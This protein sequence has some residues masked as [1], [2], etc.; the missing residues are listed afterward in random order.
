M[1]LP[2]IRC[3]HGIVGM[4]K[5]FVVKRTMGED[6]EAQAAPVASQLIRRTEEA[7]IHFFGLPAQDKNNIGA[8]FFLVCLEVAAVC[9]GT[10]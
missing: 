1:L 6:R 2:I 8:V 10:K 7:L 3:R 5:N 9:F 4:L